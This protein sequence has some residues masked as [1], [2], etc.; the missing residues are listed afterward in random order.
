M[1]EAFTGRR[2][3]SR[4]QSRNWLSLKSNHRESKDRY[5]WP[6][7]VALAVRYY[8]YSEVT[9]IVEVLPCFIANCIFAGENRAAC[10]SVLGTS[11]E[12]IRAQEKEDEWGFGQIVPLLL[13]IIPALTFIS[14]YHGKSEAATST[15]AFAA[16]VRCRCIEQKTRGETDTISAV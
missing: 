3:E 4:R 12:G 5:S 1:G 11:I 2:E 7:I 8:W 16:N 9:T 10:L 14:T 6:Q 13:L 15:S